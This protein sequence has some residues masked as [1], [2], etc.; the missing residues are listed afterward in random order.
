MTTREEMTVE[1]HARTALQFLEHSDRE[2]AAGD[3]MQGSEKLWGAASHA[4]TA[5]AMQRGWRFGKY[6]HRAAAVDRLGEEFNDLSLPLAYA[7]A[8][9]FHANFYFDF[10][11]DEEAA[12]DRPMVHDF[13]R[14]IVAMEEESAA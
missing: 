3:S 10:M 7:V 9:K 4:V 5:I 14:R 13:V 12:H 6:G 2:F 1:E 11:E 8:R